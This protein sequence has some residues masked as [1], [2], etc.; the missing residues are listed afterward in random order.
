[1]YEH[2]FIY[3]I[4]Q[5]YKFDLYISKETYIKTIANIKYFPFLFNAVRSHKHKVCIFRNILLC[6]TL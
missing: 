3:M 2:V 5:L 4:C 6:V 1:M